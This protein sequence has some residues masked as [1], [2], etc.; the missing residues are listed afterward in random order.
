MQTEQTEIGFTFTPA[1][2]LEALP[3]ELARILA[4]VGQAG[5]GQLAAADYQ[6]KGP[7]P[8]KDGDARVFF[9]QGLGDI[10]AFV[11][12]RD[13]QNRDAHF[14]DAQQR[15][16]GGGDDRAMHP[17]AEKH[18]AAVDDQIDTPLEG[19]LERPE[20]I[21][22]EIIATPPPLNLRPQRRV[23]A[24]VSVGQKEDRDRCGH[25]EES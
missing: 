6:V 4:H 1:A 5:D 9:E 11:V 12:A 2:L 22:A 19:W 14:G 3:E 15:R 25:G 20:I 10:G 21:G 24:K 23:E 13:Y 7:R 8:V 16:K 17:A 18:I